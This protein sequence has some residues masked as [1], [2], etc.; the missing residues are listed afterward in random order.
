MD[1]ITT[2]TEKMTGIPQDQLHTE[3]AIANASDA[4]SV[5]YVLE[6]DDTYTLTVV[7]PASVSA[8]IIT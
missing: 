5:D 2:T 6:A 4:I 3:I 8:T 1:S 7:Y